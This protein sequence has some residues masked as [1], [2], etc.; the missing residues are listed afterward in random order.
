MKIWLNLIL[1]TS[2]KGFTLLE[3]LLASIMT[4]FVVSATGY[5]VLV[6]TQ[7]SM[8]S[9]VAS[10]TQSNLNRAMDFI[11]DEA[12][13]AS[14][15]ST[16]ATAATAAATNFTLPSQAT[17][18]L[19]LNIAGVSQPVIYYVRQRQS[20]D[21][22]L[23]PNIIYRWGPS[24][25]GNGA[26]T[27]A[28]TP[29]NWQHNALVDAIASTSYYTSG[30]N[31]I[32]Y[33]GVNQQGQKK[34]PAGASARV[35]T[36]W[37]AIPTTTPFGSNTGFFACVRND[38]SQAEIHA[39]ASLAT[40]LSNRGIADS[41]NANN[42]NTDKA[43]YGVVTFVYPRSTSPIIVTSTTVAAISQ[44][45][46]GSLTATGCSSALSVTYVS[47]TNGT[48]TTTTS[49][50]PSTTPTFQ[51]LIYPASPNTNA[52]LTISGM[53]FS[54]PNTTDNVVTFTNGSCIVTASLN[55]P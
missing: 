11:A 9:D 14:S 26:Y 24:I 41:T 44:T 32:A 55:T 42:R 15:I 47:S 7:Q 18:V 48:T 25:D 23:G 28:A 50:T 35:T 22:W 1:R 6:M 39:Y 49:W 51:P 53:T 37:L 29:A 12:K 20:T 38:G 43:T 40:E 2:S 4:F 5:A 45:A 46:Q 21:V 30:G 52:A 36:D 3:L 54:N 34:C 27:N 17:V 19:G 31:N 8:V 33:T 13:S 10:D 16:T